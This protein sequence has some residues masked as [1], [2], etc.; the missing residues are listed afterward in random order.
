MSQLVWLVTGC[1]SGFGEA[2]ARQI[3]ARGDKVIATARN[4]D[5]RLTELKESG[6][7]VLDLD[8][9]LPFAEIE[10]KVQEAIAIYGHIDVLVNN[11][12]ESI[13]PGKIEE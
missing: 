4:G 9:A 7:D 11:A 12:G 8:V 1:S 6:T 3:L 2:F 13:L 10:Q 5:T